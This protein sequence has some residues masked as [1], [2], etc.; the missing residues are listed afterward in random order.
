MGWYEDQQH[1]IR[2]FLDESGMKA[3]D[4]ARIAKDFCTCEHCK[5]F[6]Q[7]YDSNGKMV[8]FGHCNR[9][10]HRARNPYEAPCGFWEAKDNERRGK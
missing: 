1:K 5:Y 10:K 3:Y 8:E 7:H 4:L 9:T 6:V 2:V